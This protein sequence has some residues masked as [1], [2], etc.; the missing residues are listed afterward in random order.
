MCVRPGV[1]SAHRLPDQSLGDVEDSTSQV[2]GFPAQIHADE[3]GD[4]VVARAAGTEL[5]AKRRAGSL[6]EA[7]LQRGVH[8]L[9]V[10]GRG[11]RTRCNVSVE[12]IQRFVHV[13]AFLIGQQADTMQL[14]SVRVRSGDVYVGQAEVEVRRH[15]QRRQ[16]LRRPAGKAA[17]P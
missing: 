9:I 8:V 13:G 3:G 5:A 15:A 2:S 7:T 6:D 1:A 12:A 16:S 4:L 11:E 14:I 10:D 17:T